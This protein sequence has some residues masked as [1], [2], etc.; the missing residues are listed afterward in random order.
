MR[1]HARHFR[2]R[3]LVAEGIGAGK[4]SVGDLV[5]WLGEYFDRDD[6]LSRALLPEVW[7]V[8]R[9]ETAGNEHF[10]VRKEFLRLHVLLE[11]TQGKR[12]TKGLEPWG[13]LRVGYL[14]LDET[15]PTVQRWAR[16]LGVE[17]AR[18]ADGFAGLLDLYRRDRTVWDD[19]TKVFTT[20]AK[21]L[22]N[23]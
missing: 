17:P 16:E 6:S 19:E 15:S 2:M 5:V 11:L 8:A 21:R 20:N 23:L 4:R 12:Q 18:M 14:G 13:R 10:R 3:A 1:D 7:D 22:F 9:R